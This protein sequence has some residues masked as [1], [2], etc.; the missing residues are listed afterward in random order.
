MILH[1]VENHMKRNLTV[2]WHKRD[3]PPSYA[4]NS[5]ELSQVVVCII[6]CVSNQ[7]VVKMWNLSVRLH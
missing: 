2:S 7:S 6:L 4:T 5:H 1:H 3:D